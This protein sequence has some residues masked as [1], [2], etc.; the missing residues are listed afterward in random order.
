MI[1]IDWLDDRLIE[2]GYKSV[3]YEATSKYQ[4]IQIVDTVDHGKM[5]ILDG[6]VNLAESDRKSYTHKLMGLPMVNYI[7]MNFGKSETIY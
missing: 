6:L 3:L 7:Q 1:L 5:L 4:H 2:Y